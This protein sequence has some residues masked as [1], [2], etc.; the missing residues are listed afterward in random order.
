MREVLKIVSSAEACEDLLQLPVVLAHSLPY[1][2]S[3]IN[4]NLHLQASMTQ[5]EVNNPG[6]CKKYTARPGTSF[7]F[8]LVY[9]M[10][11]GHIPLRITLPHYSSSTQPSH[12]SILMM[13][14]SS[15]IPSSSSVSPNHSLS[16]YYSITSFQAVTQT[17]TCAAAVEI[18]NNNNNKSPRPLFSYLAYQAK[19]WGLLAVP[20]VQ[21][22]SKVIH[23]CNLVKQGEKWSQRVKELVGLLHVVFDMGV[24]YLVIVW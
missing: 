8:A 13:M 10:F 14:S 4:S 18:R 17:P 20:F 11:S 24:Y 21:Q 15:H 9:Q 2:D 6:A 12:P 3:S 22:T 19:K 16:E 5:L 7:Q 1:H 23:R